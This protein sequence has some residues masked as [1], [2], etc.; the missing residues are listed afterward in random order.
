MSGTGNLSISAYTNIFPSAKL[1]MNGRSIMEYNQPSFKA[2]HTVPT[3]G[4]APTM[5]SSRVP[6]KDFSYYPSIFYKR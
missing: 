5:G 1:K 6:I 2:T 4:Y 3:N